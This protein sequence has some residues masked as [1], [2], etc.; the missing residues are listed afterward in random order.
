MQS[1]GGNREF[2]PV[3]LKEANIKMV[4]G[5]LNA[6]GSVELK[7]SSLDGSTGNT[8]PKEVLSIEASVKPFI[9]LVWIGV[10]IMAA[11][12][13]ISAFRRSKESLAQISSP[14]VK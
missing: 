5:N 7:V 9:S 10:L 8:P 12:F 2:I 1:T 3:E 13:L 6:A 11:G 4:M 14:V